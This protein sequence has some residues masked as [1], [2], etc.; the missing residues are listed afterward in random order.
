MPEGAERVKLTEGA[1]EPKREL[2]DTG[3]KMTDA[4]AVM[5]AVQPVIATS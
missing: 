4:D 2:F 5:D 1:I 3:L